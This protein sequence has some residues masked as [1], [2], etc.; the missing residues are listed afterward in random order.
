MLESVTK[1]H[2]RGSNG[3][4]CGATLLFL[5]LFHFTNRGTATTLVTNATGTPTTTTQNHVCFQIGT[6]WEESSLWAAM[7]WKSHENV[8]KNPGKHFSGPWIQIF[9]FHGLFFRS[10]IFYA[11]LILVFMAYGIAMKYLALGFMSHEKLVCYR[12][13]GPWKLHSE[14]SHP[15]NNEK[16]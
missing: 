9:H 3:V 11:K 8:I 4:L 2:L 1:F 7:L 10:W 12:F 14:I 16:W 15:V 6:S 13:H 5:L